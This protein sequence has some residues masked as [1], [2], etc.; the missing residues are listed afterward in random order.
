[1]VRNLIDKKLN[2]KTEVKKDSKYV[3]PKQTAI[4]SNDEKRKRR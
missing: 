3:A 2:S 4:L 1:M